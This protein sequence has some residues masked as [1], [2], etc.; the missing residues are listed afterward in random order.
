MLQ[1]LQRVRDALRPPA[2]AQPAP[3]S[4]SIFDGTITA[5][6]GDRPYDSWPYDGHLTDLEQGVLSF[7][8]AV[9][10]KWRTVGLRAVLTIPAL[11]YTAD[12]RMGDFV[13]QAGECFT[14]IFRLKIA[15]SFEL[16]PMFGRLDD[17][18]FT[19]VSPLQ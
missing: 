18:H 15:P 13:L 1:T 9:R 2:A 19:L 12:A 17:R 8:V 3:R 6:A 4:P 10:A 5:Y 16:W 11:N 7:P 14:L